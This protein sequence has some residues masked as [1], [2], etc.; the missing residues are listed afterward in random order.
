MRDALHSRLSELRAEFEAG[1]DQ[2]K[3]LQ[4]QEMGMQNLLFRISGAIQVLEE[5]LNSEQAKE[6]EGSHS[7]NGAAVTAAHVG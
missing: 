5:L 2:L 4:S 1:Q 3:K 6:R 7:T